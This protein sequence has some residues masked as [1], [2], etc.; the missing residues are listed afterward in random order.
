MSKEIFWCAQTT[1][2]K[3]WVDTNEGELSEWNFLHT[4]TC[5]KALAREGGCVSVCVSVS[6]CPS[7]PVST[8]IYVH[9]ALTNSL[10]RKH[11]IPTLTPVT[12]A[13]TLMTALLTRQPCP[14]EVCMSIRVRKASLSSQCYFFK[15]CQIRAGITSGWRS[16]DILQ[17]PGNRMENCGLNTWLVC[18]LISLLVV[19]ARLAAPPTDSP[20]GPVH[21]LV[22]PPW[23][24]P[25]HG[26]L[27]GSQITLATTAR[28]CTAR[29]M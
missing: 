24:F 13:L 20:D 8:H 26:L 2:E 10:I 27:S 14:S 15:L 21:G 18:S 25:T 1:Q 23:R 9:A 16:R 28:L 7:Q 11:T 12:S 22:L 6:P 4:C 5:T 3:K 19:F 17:T 29:H